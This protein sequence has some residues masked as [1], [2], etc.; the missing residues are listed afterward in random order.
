MRTESKVLAPFDE[1]AQKNELIR[2]ALLTGSRV[3]PNSPPDFL[4]DYDI[5]IYVATLSPFQE[6]DSWLNNTIVPS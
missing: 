6:D 4:S 3:N 2:A 1:W 5:S